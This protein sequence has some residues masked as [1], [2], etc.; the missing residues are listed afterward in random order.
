MPLE[1]GAGG[2]YSGISAFHEVK[3][4]FHNVVIRMLPSQD[5]NLAA[6][7]YWSSTLLHLSGFFFWRGRAL[8]QAIAILAKKDLLGFLP[9]TQNSYISH[10]DE[11]FW[12]KKWWS[13]FLFPAKKQ[14]KRKETSTLWSCRQFE[15]MIT[16]EK[17]RKFKKFLKEVLK[18]RLRKRGDNEK[19][20]QAAA[21][22][23]RLMWTVLLNARQFS[24][25]IESLDD[26]LWMFI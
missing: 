23:S 24:N 5:L 6:K 21:E 2:E 22:T 26:F 10:V 12:R 14:S 8:S 11:Q 1:F 7:K 17:F 25:S 19:E 15:D 13:Q 4:N 18:R 20:T 3:D 16:T 9:R